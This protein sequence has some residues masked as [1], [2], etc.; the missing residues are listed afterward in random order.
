MPL[1]I[2]EPRYRELISDI[3]GADEDERGFGVVAIREGREVGVDGVKALYDVDVVEEEAILAWADEKEGAPPEERV[4]LERAAE[5]V[6][7]L[8]EEGSCSRVAL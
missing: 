3:S 1:H 8:R 7:W 6:D 4:F 2:F 5:F